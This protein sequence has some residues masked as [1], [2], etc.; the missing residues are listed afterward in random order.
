[1]GESAKVTTPITEGEVPFEAPN[2]GKPCKT[3]YKVVGDLA[4][5]PHPPL[6]TLHG[7]PGAGSDYFEP[8]LDLWDVYSIPVI[9]YDQ[10]GCGR[11]TH[12][13]EKNGDTS[14]WTYDLFM[15]ELDN[16][17]DHLGLRD[18]RGFSII[19]QSWG[20]ML[21]ALYA[22]RRPLGLRQFIN[23]SGLASMRLHIEG[24]RILLAQMPDSVRAIVEDCE[25]RGDYENPAYQEATGMFARQ[26]MCRL[27]PFPEGI[28]AGYREM[29]E[30]DPTSHMTMVGP[31]MI[32]IQGT[33]RDYEGWTEAHKIEVETLILN[34]KYDESTDMCMEP[35]FKTIPKIKWVTIDSEKASHMIHYEE[36]ERVIELCG[37]FLTSRTP[38]AGLTR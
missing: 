15:A 23:L 36:R 37:N 18:T 17:V 6:V 34:G 28:M 31:A 25:R 16:L 2:A 26:H 29:N 3:W 9:L 4:T 24:L 11:S 14:F 5:S 1:M 32:D 19:G 35:W 30:I 12:L 8:L 21:G 10:V 33:L 20:G 27:D 22:A 7:G 38:T 13:Q